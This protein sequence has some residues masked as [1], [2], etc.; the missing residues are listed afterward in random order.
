M[1]KIFVLCFVILLN[2]NLVSGGSID[3]GGDNINP[4]SN[5]IINTSQF[6]Q[7]NNNPK[8]FNYVDY[9]TN[10]NKDLFKIL[11]QF[12]IFI[13]IIACISCLFTQ[14]VKKSDDSIFTNYNLKPLHYWLLNLGFTLIISIFMVLVFDGMDYISRTISYIFLNWV[15]GWIFSVLGYDYFLKYIF[16]GFEIIELKI[17]LIY[18]KL[19]KEYESIKNINTREDI[20]IKLKRIIENEKP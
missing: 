16:Y 6:N 15:C 3:L 14:A 13:L 5:T 9:L 10:L 8:Q 20:E 2:F 17:K 1:K 11:Q 19:N 12:A 18:E 7:I 4:N